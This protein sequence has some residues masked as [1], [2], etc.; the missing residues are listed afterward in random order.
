MTAIASPH[1][2]R[3]REFALSAELD[4][5][6]GE[7][8]LASGEPILPGTAFLELALRTVGLDDEGLE[9]RDVTIRAP[10]IV[11]SGQTRVLHGAVDDDGRL[12][13]ADA[14]HPDDEVFTARVASL[15]P[16][17]QPPLDPAGVASRL[18]TGAPGPT[19]AEASGAIRFGPRW[20]NV[21]S[22]RLGE[23][24]ALLELE[25]PPAFHEDLARTTLHP[26]LMDIATAGAQALIPGWSE[27]HPMF[28]PVSYG[29]VRIYRPLPARL[30]S[31]VVYRGD[32]ESDGA[33]ALFDVTL[34]TP[35]G[36]VLA[37][38]TP[39]TLMRVEDPDQLRHPASA[40]HTT[41]R[42]SP[43]P[44][45]IAGLT[46]EEGLAAFRQALGPEAGAHVLV[47]PGH[48]ARHLAELRRPSHPAGPTALPNLDLG[49]LEAAL[50]GLPG[51][52][53]SALRGRPGPDGVAQIAAYVVLAPA[54]PL[55]VSEIRRSL[56]ERLPEG[57]LPQ[58]IVEM[59]VLPRQGD[60]AVDLAALPDPFGPADGVLAPETPTQM[61]VADLWRELLG[62]ER[63]SLRDNFFDIGGHSLL[64]IRLI[65]RL[66]QATGVRLRH[67][68]VVVNTLEQIAARLDAGAASAA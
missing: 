59:D 18:P 8:R 65:S 32:G 40:A 62:V 60:G 52:R 7:H 5:M 31:R 14:A 1:T 34:A 49:P 45:L 30:I 39:L 61:L 58:I 50:S 63:V 29:R 6:L 48:P 42:T 2:G 24:E 37:D 66:H 56:R 53:E 64:S 26:A 9:L 33:L 57:P 68:D 20:Q 47:T 22:V 35:E 41:A 46:V 23:G 44:P 27:T 36:V 10:V 25:L 54:A 51:L 13:L 11:T 12:R 67:E 38:V 16:A 15:P 19:T 55:T 17:P 3:Q 28:V 21:T 4:W 43:A